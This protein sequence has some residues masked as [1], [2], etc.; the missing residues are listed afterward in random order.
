MFE[1]DLNQVIKEQGVSQI[2]LAKLSGLSKNTIN[3][4]CR[5]GDQKASLSTVNKICSALNTSP[6]TIIKYRKDH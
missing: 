1:W 3:T 6:W 2:T 5:G 4:L